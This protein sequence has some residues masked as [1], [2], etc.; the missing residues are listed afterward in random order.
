SPRS[1]SS[2]ASPPTNPVSVEQ[3]GQ[4]DDAPTTAV[5]SPLATPEAVL[6]DNHEQD[7]ASLA[8]PVQL[9]G[10]V[11]TTS[12]PFDPTTL[13]EQIRNRFQASEDGTISLDAKDHRVVVTEGKLSF[14]PV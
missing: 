14:E 10:A 11:D 1:F 4:S 3:A 6:E 2:I 13:T 9:A 8:P 5:S 12:L 7:R